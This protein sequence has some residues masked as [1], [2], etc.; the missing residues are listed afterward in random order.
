MILFFNL[1][2]IYLYIQYVKNFG[3]YKSRFHG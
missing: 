3:G 2:P 1:G